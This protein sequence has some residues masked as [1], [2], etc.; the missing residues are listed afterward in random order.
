MKTKSLV[1]ANAAGLTVKFRGTMYPVASIADAVTKWDGFR[2]A[3]VNNLGGG[4]SQIGEGLTV[5]HGTKPVAKISY[6]GRVWHPGK[7]T[8][9]SKTMTAEEIAAVDGG[10]TA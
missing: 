5:R 4:A 9:E 8:P 2:M 10:V 6:N 3:A 7:W 1:P